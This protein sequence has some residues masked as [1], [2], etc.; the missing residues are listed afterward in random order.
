M[1]KT[2]RRKASVFPESG[3]EKA[4]QVWAALILKRDLEL[5]WWGNDEHLMK[6]LHAIT[7]KREPNAA[8]WTYLLKLIHGPPHWKP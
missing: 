8:E 5:S 6:N 1:S 7:G 3:N 2:N 4:D